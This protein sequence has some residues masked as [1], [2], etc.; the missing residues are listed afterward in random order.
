[1]NGHRYITQEM[2][3]NLDGKCKQQEPKS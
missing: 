3:S 1:L 2:Q